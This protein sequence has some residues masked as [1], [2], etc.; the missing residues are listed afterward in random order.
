MLNVIRV[1][2]QVQDQGDLFGQ[3]LYCVGRQGIR[4]V[5]TNVIGKLNNLY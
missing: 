2:C 5:V 4:Q 1:C 3:W